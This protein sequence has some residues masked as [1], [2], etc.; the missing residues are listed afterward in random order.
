MVRGLFITGTGTGV[1]KTYVASLLAR[2]IAAAGRKVGVYKPAASGCRLVEGQ[3]VSADALALWEAAGRPG[4][5][6]RVC[7]Q[8]FAA[9]LA[10]HL[11]ARR[12]GRRLDPLLL[13]QGLDYWKSRSE[14]VLVEGAGGLMSPLGEKEYVGDL[15]AEFG[16]P[17]LVVSRNVLGTINATL[18]TLVAAKSFRSDSGGL[19]VAGII[20]NNPTPPPPA[21]LSLASNRTELESRIAVPLLAEVA[22][23]AES[24][25]LAADWFTLAAEGAHAKAQRRKGM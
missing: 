10:P 16:F 1:G 11:A 3:L 4:E 21:D 23:G 6:A 17:L 13:R 24:L 22:W 20:L 15:A 2:A 19:P 14:I 18:Q 25:D 7:P 9:P 8:C 5:F 12:E